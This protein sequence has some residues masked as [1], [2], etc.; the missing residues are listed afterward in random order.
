LKIF[1]YYLRILRC[2][3]FEL[4]SNLGFTTASGYLKI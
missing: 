3:R 1:Q 2:Y 4:H